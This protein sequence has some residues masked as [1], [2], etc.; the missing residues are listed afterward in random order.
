MKPNSSDLR[1]CEKCGAVYDD[2]VVR[3]TKECPSCKNVTWG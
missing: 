3:N 1:T 2:R